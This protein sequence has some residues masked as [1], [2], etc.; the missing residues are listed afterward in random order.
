MKRGMAGGTHR[1][2]VGLSRQRRTIRLVQL[3]LVVIAAALLMFSGYS[4]GRVSGFEAGR[5]S[6]ELE[7]SP[8]PSLTQVMVLGVLGTGALVAAVLLQ[9]NGGVRMPTP[10]RLDDLAGI[11]PE[12]VSDVQSR[13]DLKEH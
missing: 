5:R 12:R 9:G 13:G 6:Q 11:G 3:L 7:S 8:K 1:G 2:P 4:L 10:A